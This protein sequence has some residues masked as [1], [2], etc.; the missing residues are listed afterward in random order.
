MPTFTK[1][2]PAFAQRFA[3]VVLI[4]GPVAII[5]LGMS[6]HEPRWSSAPRAVAQSERSAANRM[7]LWQSSTQAT[8]H[9][10]LDEAARI[11][12]LEAD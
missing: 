7:M 9:R 5:A 4:G 8:S 11:S 10:D 3:H 12:P 2:A 6:T 1:Q